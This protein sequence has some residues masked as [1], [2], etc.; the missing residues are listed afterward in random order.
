ME[1]PRKIPERLRTE[2]V[3]LKF[4]ILEKY[5]SAD[6]DSASVGDAQAPFCDFCGRA[7][8][9]VGG[10]VGNGTGYLHMCDECVRSAYAMLFDAPE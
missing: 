2:L 9:E 4:G 8:N 5:A 3:R 7:R 6:P 1:N 10:M